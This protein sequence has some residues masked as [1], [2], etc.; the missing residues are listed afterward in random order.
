MLRTSTR[1]DAKRSET[2]NQTMINEWHNKEFEKVS[3]TDLELRRESL[4]LCGDMYS[5]I[6]NQLDIGTSFGCRHN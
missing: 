1:K 5:W 2:N 4:A 6:A 3:S